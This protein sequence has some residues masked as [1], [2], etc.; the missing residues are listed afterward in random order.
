MEYKLTEQDFSSIGNCK[1]THEIIN[2]IINYTDD[3]E[4]LCGYEFEDFPLNLI[5]H[6]KFIDIVNEINNNIQIP[7]QRWKIFLQNL[8]KIHLTK[9]KKV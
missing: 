3:E 6:K 9:D 7:S 5:L 4:F 8:R 2:F 1:N